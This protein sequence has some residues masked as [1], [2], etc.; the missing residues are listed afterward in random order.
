MK[1]IKF[2]TCAASGERGRAWAGLGRIHRIQP[3]NV[4]TAA[5][6]VAVPPPRAD[7]SRNMTEVKDGQVKYQE[8]CLSEHFHLQ[9]SSGTALPYLTQAQLLL[10]DLKVPSSPIFIL[11]SPKF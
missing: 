4:P 10:N 9:R 8:N 3:L 11:P 6:G 2:Q 5:A 7:R 1:G